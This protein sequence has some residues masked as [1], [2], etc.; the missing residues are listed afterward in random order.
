MLGIWLFI[1]QNLLHINLNIK[2]LKGDRA[3]SVGA[4]ALEQFATA[5]TYADFKYLLKTYLF[6]V[7]FV[8]AYV[9]VG[10][11]ALFVSVFLV[12]A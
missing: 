11:G 12:F 2:K 7:V 6:I 3:F 10:V 8:G 5:P 9:G 4:L 1:F